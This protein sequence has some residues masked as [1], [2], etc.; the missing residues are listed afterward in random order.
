MNRKL[1]KRTIMSVAIV[2][3]LLSGTVLAQEAPSTAAKFAVATKTPATKAKAKAPK[4]TQTLNQVVVTGAPTFLGVKRINASFQITTADQ[5]KI[6]MAMP[7]SAADLLKIVPG[8]WVESSGG[9]TGANIEIAGFPG[10]SD[11]PYVT[12]ELN[13]SPIYA[14]PTLS[15]MANDSLFRID[16]TVQRVEVLQGG[17]SVIFSNGQIGATANY[18][19]KQGT[20]KSTGS[21]GYTVGTHGYY[22]LDGFY[23]GKISTG[24]YYSI[25]GFYRTSNGI[26]SSQFPADQGGQLTA[27]L[28]HDLADGSV[29]F[30]ARVLND[31]NLFITDVPLV[32][33]NNGNSVSAFPGFN[34]LT[35]TFAGNAMRLVNIQVTPGNPP[36]TINANLANGRGA[37]I[38]MVGSNLDLY[39]DNGWSFSNKFNFTG[40]DMPTNALFNNFSPQTLSDFTATTMTAAN[41]NLSVVAAAGGLATSATATY[42]NGGGAVNPNQAVASLGFWVV[43]KKIRSLTD[44]ARISKEIFPGNTLTFGSYLASYSSNDTWYLGNNMLVTATPN[45][46]LINVTLNNGVQVTRN[47]FLGGPFYALVDSYTG[48]NIAGFLSDQWK[49]NR[50]LLDAGYR[51]ENQSVNGSV[52]NATNVDLDGNPLTLYNNNTSVTNGSFTPSTYHGTRGS[53]TLGATYALQPNMSVYARYNQGV[54]F[55]G[56]DDLRSGQPQVQKIKNFE[57]GFKMIGSDWYTSITA[58]RRLFSGVPFQQFTA[59]GQNVTSV[60]GASSHGVDFTAHWSPVENFAMDLTGDWQNSKYEHYSSAGTGTQAGY[61]YIG[62]FLQRQP[63]FQFRFTP[64]YR[65]PTQWGDVML[66]ATYSHV[67]FRYSDIANTQP[68]PAYYMLNAGV[69]A[70]VG[71]HLQFRLEGSNLT[72]Q[73]GLTEG[74]ARVTNSGI[75]NGL[76]MARPIFGRQ[77][78]FQ[79]RYKF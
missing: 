39:F 7:S 67:G 25:G 42:V 20:A 44:E 65:I 76:E 68:L 6:R 70:N 40:G 55:P 53:W 36:G 45:A 11:A 62:N 19:L 71:K 13:G 5:S 26:R 78:R 41:A 30:Y 77:I 29:M 22:R 15:F 28:S 49:I 74:N 58:F 3:A 23:G 56:F 52:S 63:K 34:P 51:S 66:F 46:Q 50:W 9:E 38:H 43:N 35:G 72:N 18:I 31:K 59:T 57:V 24:W 79:A 1:C 33:T 12:V 60:Y 73:L 48:R 37:N 10:G 47:G 64:S 21:V 14:A 16:D 61:N 4:S 69:I 8:L 27:T 2:S 54:H 17:P 32:T 75:V